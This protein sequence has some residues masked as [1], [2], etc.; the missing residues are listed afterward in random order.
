MDREVKDYEPHLALDGGEDGLDYYRRIATEAPK[1]LTRGGMVIL[2][3]GDGQASDVAKLFKNAEYTMII[4]DLAGKDR[5][6][7]AIF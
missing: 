6:V 1:C 7:K 3:V 5:F 2:E 4:K